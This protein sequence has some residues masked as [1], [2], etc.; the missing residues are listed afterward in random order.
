MSERSGEQWHGPDQVDEHYLGGNIRAPTPQSVTAR[1]VLAL[2]RSAYRAA[3]LT[4]TINL[5]PEGS[6]TCVPCRANLEC[7][8]R[9]EAVDSGARF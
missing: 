5:R 2:R 7:A 6:G 8:I 4:P 9:C 1:S 3:G